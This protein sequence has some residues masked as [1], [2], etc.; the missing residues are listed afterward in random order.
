MATTTNPLKRFK[1]LLGS[2]SKQIAKVITVHADG[3]SLVELRNGKRFVVRGDT[4]EE[5]KKAWIVDS[6]IISEAPDLPSYSV[7]I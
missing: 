6:E 5:T 1:N 3:T 2:T 7:S 4:V